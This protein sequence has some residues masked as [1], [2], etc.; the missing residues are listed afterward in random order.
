MT[1]L[2]TGATGFVGKQLVKTLVGRGNKVRVLT[3]NI[4]KAALALGD[5]AELIYWNTKQLIA[6]E[7]LEGVEAVFN[8]AGES[9]ASGKWTKERKQEIYDSRVESTTLLFKSFQEA[10]IKPKVFVST[11]AIGI[12]GD[13]GVEELSED[14]SLSQDFLAQVCKDWEA[15]VSDYAFAVERTVILRVG[16]VLGKNGGALAKMLP[17]F[18]M[19]V[20]GPIGCGHQYM[21][22][23]HIDDLVGLYLRAMSDEQMQ[24]VF[25]A[26]SPGAVTNKEFSK[27]LGKV[28]KRPALLCAPSVAI[29]KAFGEMSQILLDSQKVTPKRA[30]EANFSFSFDQLEPALRDILS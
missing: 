23:I 30:K 11:S 6:K 24:G 22:W 17:P 26:V 16:I 19:F 27:T 7:H 4:A 28:L 15:A 5:G 3:R 13:R 29:E 9:I 20:G 10:Q 2:V 12:Y 21:S 14:S 18:K 1:I 25:N 8:L